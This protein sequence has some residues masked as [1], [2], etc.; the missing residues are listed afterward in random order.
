MALVFIF[1]EDHT[2]I[3]DHGKYCKT[4]E[5][6]ASGLPECLF[7]SGYS[8]LETYSTMLA[9]YYD[10][11]INWAFSS[12]MKNKDFATSD[13]GG[14]I[15]YV[16]DDTVTLDIPMTVENMSSFFRNMKLKYNNGNGTCNIVTFLGVDFVDGMQLKC[17]IRLS[18]DSTKLVYPEML[19]FIKNPDIAV[20]PQTSEE[21]CR[22][23]AN[24]NPLDLEHIL[25]LVTLSLLQE[26]MLSYHYCLH[27]KPFPKLITLAEKGKIPKRLASLKGRCPIC[28]PCLFG[29]AHKCPWH[30]K[31]KE[32]HPIQRKS[33]NYPGARASMDHLV[34]AQPGLI[35]I[36]R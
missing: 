9:S 23:A 5:T 7:S 34:S 17:N 2:L 3:W 13:E 29:K 32:L 20:I 35:V 25:K 1:Y 12:K 28:I 22:D 10:D 14:A 33:D 16:T 18:D 6:H 15:V 24:L 27:Y 8:R 26:E 19:N 11:T 31:S 21:Y 4:F 36:G 30:S